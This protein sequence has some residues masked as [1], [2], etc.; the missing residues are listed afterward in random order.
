VAAREASGEHRK[1]AIAAVAA[2]TGVPK[3]IVFD[4]V[5]QAKG[6]GAEVEAEA[7]AEAD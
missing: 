3:R 1:A 6:G 2:E 7:E 4:A 5:V